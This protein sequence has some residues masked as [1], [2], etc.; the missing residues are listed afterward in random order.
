MSSDKK[1]GRKE[2]V[3]A[4]AKK[5]GI[6]QAKADEILSTV[7]DEI[8]N[9]VGKGISVGIVGFGTFSPRARAA[10]TGRNPA[11][12]ESLKIKASTVPAFKAGSVFKAVVAKS[13]VAKKK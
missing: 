11:T 1:I 5:H 8:Q 10:R 12:G 13:K 7:I 4:L 3:V 9:N 6:S 2:M